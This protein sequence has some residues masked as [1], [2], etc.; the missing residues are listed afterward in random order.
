MSLLQVV[1]E[2]GQ[3]FLL[4]FALIIT[5]VLFRKIRNVI[6]GFRKALPLPAEQNPEPRQS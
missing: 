1:P 3:L 6:S 4:G 2:S 5:G